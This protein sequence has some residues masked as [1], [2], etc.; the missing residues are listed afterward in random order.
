MTDETP[1]DLRSL[2]SGEAPDLARRAVRRFRLHVVLFTV[3]CVVVASVAVGM[4]VAWT[5]KDRPQ[6][7]AIGWT[8][9]QTAV[10][11]DLVGICRTPTWDFGDLEV[12]LLDAV[13]MEGGA[14]ALH[15]ALHG[16]VA[17]QR[18][19]DDGSSYRETTSIMAVDGTGA[20]IGQAQAQPGATWG[21]V[22]LEVPSGAVPMIELQIQGPS[23]NSPETFTVDT[24][25]LRVGC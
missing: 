25:R 6:T 22:Y 21:E 17:E 23:L 14:Y 2:D 18:D 11:N 9:A 10:L 7:R 19:T 13:R 15:F 1:L 4:V 12:G 5:L 16:P 3:L 24:D 20:P 8:P